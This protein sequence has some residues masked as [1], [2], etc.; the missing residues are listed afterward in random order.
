MKRMLL[1]AGIAVLFTIH[2]FAGE[3]TQE[4]FFEEAS[5]VKNVVNAEKLV[6]RNTMEGSIYARD[7]KLILEADIN[8]DVFLWQSTLIINGGTVN[9]M[10]YGVDSRI[11]GGDFISNASWIAMTSEELSGYD[12]LIP[13]D[14]GPIPEDTSY[15][16][17]RVINEFVFWMIFLGA[18]YIIYLLSKKHY[19]F[20]END[21]G[22]YWY[23]YLLLTIPLIIVWSIIVTLLCITIVL[24]LVFIM[25]WAYVTIAAFAFILAYIGATLK[26]SSIEDHRSFFIG[27]GLFLGV[28]FIRIV[29][30]DI[31]G[32]TAISVLSWIV[33]GFVFAFAF[34]IG[35]RYLKY[36][37]VKK[38]RVKLSVA[39]TPEE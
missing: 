18:A 23:R 34:S 19:F 33:N 14:D 24:P 25:F 9:G 32:I 12:N 7:S 22:N 2:L 29:V 35:M 20:F 21:F 1:L 38:L 15:L 6:I 3:I 13:E 37:V 31:L 5:K 17:K 4:N 10:V 39:T 36:L 27:A 26:R 30:G 28:Q 11:T 8:G 16:V